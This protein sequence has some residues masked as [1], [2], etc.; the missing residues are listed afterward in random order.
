MQELHPGFD[1]IG[2]EQ[3]SGGRYRIL[4]V[5][6]QGG[7]GVVYEAMDIERGHPVALKTVRAPSPELIYRLKREFRTLA[8]LAHPNL[9]T[10]YDLTV[11]E[12]S[13]F[14]TMEL[15]EGADL[16]EW[17]RGKPAGS[18]QDTLPP[19]EDEP[20]RDAACTRPGGTFD[21]TRLRSAFGQLA[22]GVHVLHEAGQMHRDIKPTNVRV[23]PQ[24][25][26]V[27]LD[28]GLALATDQHDS[29][30][31]KV[32]GTVAYMSPEQAL[33]DPSVGIATD[34]YAI[35]AVLYE[36]LTGTVPFQGPVLR[37]LA[38]KQTKEAAP[39]SSRQA[40]L[41]ADLDALC[42]ALLRRNAA[43]RPLGPEV[44]RRLGVAVEDGVSSSCLSVIHAAP[45]T[46]RTQ[47]LA[48]LEATWDAV[49]RE[50]LQIALVSGPAGSGKTA[51]VRALD[52]RLETRGAQAIVLAGRCFARENVPYDALDGVVDGLCRVWARLPGEEALALLPDTDGWLL[53]R[54][55]PVLG[56][57]SVVARA[58]VERRLT[59]DAQALRTRAFGALRQVLCKLAAKR[60]VLLQ[61]DDLQWIDPDTLAL[62]EELL[63]PPN[64]PRMLAVLA[65]RDDDLEALSRLATR[66]ARDA[67]HVSLRP[68]DR[69][70]TEELARSLLGPAATPALCKRIARASR[71]SPVF[72]TELA[73]YVL[74]V[75]AS[76]M[77]DEPI[78]L[79]QAILARI[80]ALGEHAR[81]VVDLLAVSRSPLTLRALQVASGL[82]PASLDRAVRLLRV[83]HVVVG[84][85]VR[86]ED[87]LEIPSAKVREAAF[88]ALS[89]EAVKAA[90]RQIA[91][92]LVETGDGTSEAL[93][94]HWLAAGASELG[95]SH[96]RAA[97]DEAFACLD[98][99]R[100]ARFYE[101]VLQHA[102]LPREA[103]AALLVSH[104]DAL[105]FG[106]R[107]REAARE[108]MSAA[109]LV[110]ATQG[111]S[112]RR[113]AAE[114][115]LRGGY[116]EEGLAETG[117][118]LDQ[119]GLRLPVTTRGARWSILLRRC[120][121]RL[122]G[123]GWRRRDES[124]LSARALLCCDA[125]GSTALGLGLVDPLRGLD[126]HVRHLLSAL[127]LGEPSRVGRALVF[128]ASFLA[129][130]GRA[131]RARRASELAFR[132]AEQTDD[133]N[134]F[135]TACWSDGMRR[136]FTGREFKEAQHRL[137]DTAQLF[138]ESTRSGWEVA[139]AK[140]Y[141]CFS[142]AYLGELRTL[143]ERVR[144]LVAEAD[145]CADR[146]SS[147]NYRARLGIVWLSQGEVGHA[148]EDID[149]AMS[150][151]VPIERGYL[152]QHC[153]ALYGR[154]EALLYQ[155]RPREA[156]EHLLRELPLLARSRL[157]DVQLLRVEM[158]Y[159]RARCELALAARELA[160]RPVML[161]SARRHAHKLGRLGP[162]GHALGRLVL[163]GVEWLGPSP[164]QAIESLRAAAAE[165]EACE[166]FLY[167]RA[168]RW[169]LSRCG[170]TPEDAASV[171]AVRWM[172]A[173]QVREPD[174]LAAMLIPLAPDG[175]GGRQV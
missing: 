112:L 126:A 157:L 150:S 154:C 41:P 1:A 139:T 19:L 132:I 31:G 137:R 35:G 53:S 108:M 43:D 149:V 65:A 77:T 83:H 82:E 153:Y 48:Y 118:L 131:G 50:G 152:V 38:D 124:E 175:P 114:E 103:R 59:T 127:R 159:L 80:G 89:R 111:L 142:L 160:L 78:R 55:F 23:T 22:L 121:L 62:L 171:E 101:L 146:F 90:H 12:R 45:F 29:T 74:T 72:A 110:S 25:R 71:G 134:L 11:T 28:F 7:M 97:A 130:F 116:V 165:L 42:V 60:P 5:L 158:L 96:A 106:G 173:E 52:E 163:A 129:A 58:P 169:T 16:L 39:P 2:F 161:A 14:F 148:L 66:Y 47:E 122:R 32:V 40:G 13:C 36:V 100:A 156:V 51:L 61:L 98:F 9:I 102:S 138:E 10:L 56:R 6:G 75:G 24:G 145:R 155:G 34:W 46:G 85:G 115:L 73:R 93:A 18:N 125:L 170:G 64:A 79:E 88:C 27:L 117:A 95:A 104:G 17:I 120:W 63:R 119:F 49:A 30:A 99:A 105:S 54:L 123:L 107:P 164:G 174:R 143:G 26:V 91:S 3:R 168:A 15:V 44:L 67:T 87:S 144:T 21:E 20:L 76:A 151:W 69:A 172:G 141:Q 81:R 162:L 136:Y 92:A 166:A 84:Q 37:V 8:E 140:L 57:V 135:A 109:E 94:V 147:V 33:G 113:R 68:L 128:E 4:R 133:P 167:A 70:S 86:Q